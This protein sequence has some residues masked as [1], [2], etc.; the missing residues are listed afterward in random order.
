V[1]DAL[2]LRPVN[3]PH[4]ESLYEVGRVTSRIRAIWICATGTAALRTWP[5]SYSRRKG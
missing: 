5:R 2:I 3:V 4:A 1:F